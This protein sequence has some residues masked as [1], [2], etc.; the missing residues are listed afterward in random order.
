MDQKDYHFYDIDEKQNEGRHLIDHNQDYSSPQSTNHL[1]ALAAGGLSVLLL[2]VSLILAWIVFSTNKGSSINLSHA[3]ISTLAFLFAGFAAFWSFSL[4]SGHRDN[5]IVNPNMAFLVYMGSIIFTV[6]FTIAALYLWVNQ[7]F[8]SNYMK[9][10]NSV[11]SSWQSSFWGLDYNKA[12]L[13]FWRIYLVLAIFAILIAICFALLANSAWGQMSNKVQSK[14]ITL[15]VALLSILVF[16]FLVLIWYLNNNAAYNYIQSKLPKQFVYVP[17]VAFIFG[18]IA[19][20][21]AL[22]NAVCNFIKAKSVNFVFAV[23]WTGFFIVFAIFVAL[24]FKNAYNLSKQNA[25]N[26]QDAAGFISQSQYGQY[27]SS[28]YL[29]AGQFCGSAYATFGWE[30]TPAAN[31]S[32]NPTCDCNASDLMLWP[33]FVLAIFCGFLLGSVAVAAITDFALASAERDDD[34]YN[35]FHVFDLIVLAL[36]ICLAI[37][38]GFWLIFRHASVNNAYQQSKSGLNTNLK[39]ELVPTPS[40]TSVP[41]D[42]SQN[43]PVK[44]QCYF[45]SKTSLPQFATGKT[46]NDGYSVGILVTN[47]KINTSYIGNTASIGP[48]NSRQ[49]YFPNA[50]NAN[51]AF[52]NIYGK[53]NDVANALR[54]LVV[55]QTTLQI[56]HGVYLS[57]NSVDLSKIANNGL[58]N[59]VSPVYVEPY[60]SGSNPD[61][62]A[63][64]NNVGKCDT[65]CQYALTLPTNGMINIRGVLVITN[66][67]GQTVTYGTPEANVVLNLYQN[68]NGQQ[69]FIGFGSYDSSGN[70]LIQA[71]YVQNGAYKAVLHIDDPTNQYQANLVDINVAPTSTNSDLLV[72]NIYLT[73]LSG[74]GCKQTDLASTLACFAGQSSNKANLELNLQDVVNPGQTL[75]YPLTLTLRKTFSE[76]GELVSTQTLNSPTWTQNLPVGYYNAQ[77]TGSGYNSKTQTIN[78]DGNKSVNLYLEESMANGYRIYAAIDNTLDPSSDYDLNLKIRASD[79]SECVVS[80]VNKF[81]PHATHIQSISQGQKGFE[82]INVDQFTNSYYM[83]FITKNSASQVNCPYANT[84]AQRFLSRKDNHLV[85]VVANSA[86]QVFT[87]MTDSLSD[88]GASHPSS[89]VAS[90]NDSF[91]PI[92]HGDKVIIPNLF[93]ALSAQGQSPNADQ[94]FSQYVSTSDDAQL[95]GQSMPLLYSSNQIQNQSD[96]IQNNNKLSS[97]LTSPFKSNLNNGNGDQ[98]SSQSY[99]S[100]SVFNMLVNVNS[101]NNEAIRE[102]NNLNSANNFYDVVGNKQIP[103][104]M[105]PYQMSNSNTYS[106]STQS[107]SANQPKPNNN[108]VVVNAPA[109]ESESTES[110][111]QSS[112]SNETEETSSNENEQSVEASYPENET[113]TNVANPQDQINQTNVDAN[114]STVKESNE[115]LLS[116]NTTSEEDNNTLSE[117]ADSNDNNDTLSEETEIST[118]GNLNSTYDNVSGNATNENVTELEQETNADGVNN[119]NLNETIV[120]VDSSNAPESNETEVAVE[121]SNSQNSVNEAPTTTEDVTFPQQTNDNNANVNSESPSETPN[122]VVVSSVDQSQPEEDSTTVE[123]TNEAEIPPNPE[124]VN[125]IK[126]VVEVVQAPPTN[127]DD[128]S[129]Y[130]DNIIQKVITLNSN[131]SYPLHTDMIPFNKEVIQSSQN[132]AQPSEAN[133]QSNPVTDTVVVVQTP[134]NAETLSSDDQN[135]STSDVNQPT[136]TSQEETI[137]IHND[138]QP[139]EAETAEETNNEPEQQSSV[140]VINENPSSKIDTNN[141]SDEQSPQQVV[142]VSNEVNNDQAPKL[143]VVASNQVNNQPEEPNQE[144]ESSNSAEEKSQEEENQPQPE[145][146]IN[147]VSSNEIQ[148]IESVPVVINDQNGPSLEEKQV[149]VENNTPQHEEPTVVMEEKPQDDKLVLIV[150]NKPQS[151]NLVVVVENKPQE[152]TVVANAEPTPQ[153]EE[154]VAVVVENKPIDEEPVILEE[155]HTP[156]IVTINTPKEEKTASNDSTS[157]TEKTVVIIDDKSSVNGT[158]SGENSTSDNDSNEEIPDRRL[159]AGRLLQAVAPTYQTQFCFTGFGEKSI[160]PV[161][162]NGSGVPSIQSCVD[163]YPDNDS[164]SLANLKSAAN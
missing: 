146:T 95:F 162:L 7:Q 29:S 108:V 85:N 156:A 55:C 61:L 93:A 142:V 60:T 5:G 157:S 73:T 19:L 69:N 110:N 104:F 148:P 137:L 74:Q 127:Y 38:L 139:Q 67:A 32:L 125:Q 57:A 155:E 9:C 130:N 51:D 41:L 141:S 87:S 138:N 58:T 11:A 150:K 98:S 1:L 2:I 109:P 13:E 80:P 92:K 48:K 23:L 128:P 124:V 96:K 72:G 43:I 4:F 71:P 54:N 49:Y 24:L 30:L 91:N 31:A 132:V 15:G 106:S 159:R 143:V 25:F 102:S 22:L 6:Y 163:K 140:V 121:E 120:L 151:E 118:E 65:S 12:Q 26:R 122:N 35:A 144:T 64:G 88:Y 113:S 119:V 145:Q 161:N 105:Q 44:E 39:G 82:V 75:Q 107:S 83:V 70:F 149:E 50:N 116:G 46:G 154:P 18:I 123:E 111:N 53:P 117:N 20:G 81:C 136:Q 16:G 135:V 8:F 78:L 99:I 97:S 62:S 84:V 164:F 133:Q 10:A 37:A 79:G 160:K 86:V 131:G 112:S 103:I 90:T 52:I 3:I 33:W 59:G 114:N 94:L 89:Y 21:L 27:C 17:W 153:K 63:F 152:E 40:F 126:T 147:V 158:N 115:P 56:S 134:S 14:K 77:I 129:D 34:E 101:K 45:L 47:G 66:A 28:K 42:V 76:L 36:I 68:Q 100:N